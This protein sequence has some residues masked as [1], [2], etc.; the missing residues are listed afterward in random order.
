MWRH[1]R[2][3]PIRV[4]GRLGWFLALVFGA[5]LAF[6]VRQ[7]CAGW[8]L[9]Y[10]ERAAWL[11][12]WSGRVLR[13]LRVQVTVRGTP[14]SS[15]L[16]VSNH[17]SYLDILVLASR[18]PAVF[19]AK[20]EVGRWPVIGWLTRCAGTLYIVREKRLDVRRVGIGLAEVVEGGVVGVV[21]PEG[22][23]SDG[24][25]VLP[26]R[27]PLLGMAVDRGWPVTPAWIGYTLDDGRVED[28]ICYWG[29]MTFAP[30]LLN[31]FSK[32]SIRATIAFGAALPAGADRKRLALELRGRV[33]ELGSRWGGMEFSSDP[34]AGIALE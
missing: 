34:P 15:G 21:F 30:H 29:D 2:Q 12:R 10:A 28:E 5:G 18:L 24:H 33:G 14:P 13:G 19:V 16:L 9:G 11:Q 31:L 20:S 23:S 25:Q 7:V 32:A 26:F 27:A 22:T 17:L 3:H 1:L 8:R 6:V 4:T